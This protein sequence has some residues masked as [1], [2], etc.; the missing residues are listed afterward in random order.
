LRQFKEKGKRLSNTENLNQEDMH[1]MG[2]G[3]NLRKMPN[4]LLNPKVM[5]EFSDIVDKWMSA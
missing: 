2:D 4:D 5:K 3:M 1:V